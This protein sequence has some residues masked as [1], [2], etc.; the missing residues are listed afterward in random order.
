MNTILS[1][2]LP[3][4]FA[5]GAAAAALALS[6]GAPARLRLSIAAVGLLAWVIPWPLLIVPLA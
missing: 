5:S 2:L 6:S 1:M 4:L 3:A